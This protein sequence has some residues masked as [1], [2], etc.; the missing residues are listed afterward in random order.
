[1]E[2]VME[3]YAVFKHAVYRHQCGGIF[4]D[5]DLAMKAAISLR[6]GERDSHHSY[7]VV[8][9]ILDE[10]TEQT[11]VITTEGSWGTYAEG[12]ELVESKE[13]IT[14]GSKGD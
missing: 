10:K 5:I 3:V 11:P 7:E 4:T 6:D 12:G 1:M 2:R 14:V 13:D 8:P 9:F